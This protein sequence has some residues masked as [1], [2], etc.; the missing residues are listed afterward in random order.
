MNQEL[1]EEYILTGNAIELHALLNADPKLASQKTSQQISPLMLCCYYKKPELADIILKHVSEISIFEAAALG[2]SD[3]L[4]N[5]LLDNPG[6]VHEFS[7]D[8]FTPL[9]LAAYF[10]R[11]DAIRILL[12]NGSD[13][14]IPSKNGFSVYPIHSAVAS[15]YTMIAKML[16]ESGAD[17]N[18]AQKSG[19]TPLHS[20][21][22]NGNIELLIVLLEAG[23][24][25]N[26]KMEDG[27]TPADKAFEK[28]FVEIAKILS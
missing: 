12:L 27:K 13:P 4:N 15:D 21:A 24:I 8:G 11:E 23:A 25:V 6:L 1:L 22:H 5:A 28:G 3:Y 18:V 16:L 7:E 2:K 17:V 14:N 20:A 26:A 19:I 10:G 9:S